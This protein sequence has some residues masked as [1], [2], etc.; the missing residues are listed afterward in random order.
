MNAPNPLIDQFG[1]Q[2]SY[3]R[4]SL[5]DRC[6]LRCLYCMPK[7]GLKWS[8]TS[9]HLSN[10]ELVYLIKLFSEMGIR[11]VR[12]TG[13]EPTLRK[14][15]ISLV[16]RITEE[17]AGLT[18]LSMTTN[19][20]LL[21]HLA[22]PLKA[23]G[24]KRLNISIDSL[25]SDRFHTITRG[26]SLKRVLQGIDA[27]LSAGFQ[28]IKLNLVLLKDHNED[29]IFDFIDFCSKSSD[30]LELRC[31]EYMPFQARW[32][33]CLSAASIKTKILT[34]YHQLAPVENHPDRGP[35]R[36]FIIPENNVKIGFI[37][38]LSN[39]FCPSCNRL[40]LMADGSLRSCLAKEKHP[41]LREFIRKN[42]PTEQLKKT[43]QQIV[44]HKVDGHHCKED[45]GTLFEGTM[46]RI[47]G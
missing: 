14:G 1:R 3:L 6:N 47:G 44:W 26:G 2:H 24:L 32:M 16:E 20:L 46:T 35:A 15:L 39:R 12:L 43:I 30:I 7:E 37:S 21:D 9:E 11:H 22:Q 19:G 17:A 31:I 13:G 41:P 8:P 36:S 23:A 10:D 45:S 5:T 42:Y 18:D 29:E 34:R 38:P 27:S 33:K 4:V 25:D 40:R 28:K